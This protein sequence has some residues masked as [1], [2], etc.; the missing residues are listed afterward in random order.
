[1]FTTSTRRALRTL[2]LHFGAFVLAYTAWLSPAP[3]GAANSKPTP[4]TGL[5]WLHLI[6][7]QQYDQSWDH[8]SPFLK[9]HIAKDKW[10]AIL[11]EKRQPLGHIT[12]R[13][14]ATSD[15]HYH[16]P[17]IGDG[18]FQVTVY[19]TSFDTQKTLSETLILAREA[20]GKWRAIGYY[21]K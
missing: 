17:G 15:F 21:L 14:R 7:H 12:S 8:A 5:A 19:Q 1:M 16:I 13:D 2:G 10:A 18:T 9:A 20:D 3:S 11:R 6:D 4:D